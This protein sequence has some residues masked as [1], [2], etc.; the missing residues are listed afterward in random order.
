M[1]SAGLKHVRIPIAILGAL[2]A[3]ALLTAQGVAPVP[4]FDVLSSMQA[5]PE[6]AQRVER[7]RAQRVE[8]ARI[9]RPRTAQL[10]EAG[11]RG[12][13]VLVA[14]PG[15]DVVARLSHYESQPQ[16]FFAAGPL[17]RSSQ[18]GWRVDGEVAFTVV[19]GTLVGRIIVG[20]RQFRVSR[21]GTD[22]L[23]VVEEVDLVAM[24]PDGQPLAVDP[25]DVPGMAADDQ[26]GA[27]AANDSNAFVDVLMLYTPA[28]RVRFGSSAGIQAEATAAVNNANLALSNSNVTHRYRAVFVGEV[29]Y[30]ESGSSNTDLERLQA[31][32]DG[33]LDEAHGLRD[34]Y[35]AD[36][37]TLLTEASDVCG[38]GYVMGPGSVS[39]GFRTYA[40]NVTIATCASSNLSLAHEIG[41]NI[42][43]HHDRANAGSTQPSFSFAYGYAVPGVARD[44]MA[45]ACTTGG[46][47]PRRTLFSS[48]GIVFPGTSVTAGTAT[49]DNARAMGL[50][51][52]P[53]ANFRDSTC[54]YAV[55]P[56]SISVGLAGGGGSVSVTASSGCAWNAVSG[57]TSV[58]TI[59]GGA[60]STGSG[61]ASYSVGA[62][63][64]A[65][66]A[67]LTVAGQSVTVSQAATETLTVSMA[68]TTLSF[69]AT[70]TNGVLSGVTSAQTV[71]VTV[72]NGSAVPWTA[73]ASQSWVQITGGSGTGNGSFVV[74][75]T[76]PGNVLSGV[77]SASATITLAPTGATS[78]TTVSVGLTVTQVSAGAVPFGQVDTPLQNA[79]G[80]Q[81]AIGVTGWA[82]DDTGLASIRVY[83][84]CLSVDNPLSCQAILGVQ[85]VFLGDASF[86]PGARPDVETAFPGYP[87]ANRAGWGMQ[88]LTNML[89]HIPNGV[90]VGGQGAMTFYVFATDNG[91]QVSLLGRAWTREA[92]D[93][94]FFAPTTVTLANDS[95]AKP[96]GTIDTPA[97]GATLSGSVANFGWVLTP[98]ANTQAGE[99]GDILMPISGA[100]MVAY[101]DGVART[102]VAYNQCRG[103]VG[104]PVAAGVFC[105]DDIANTFGNATAQA[106]LT[107]R[108]SNPSRY[109]NLDAGRS[110]IGAVVLNT[111][112]LT[113]GLH[114]IAWGVSDSA[115]RG[116]GIGS[117]FFT[118]ANAGAGDLRSAGASAP[119]LRHGLKPV[120]SIESARSEARVLGRTGFSLDALWQVLRPDV[121]GHRYARLP[122]MGRLEL[123]LG[124]DIDEAYQIVAG[125]LRALPIGS[126]VDGP[127]FS[128]HPGPGFVGRYSLV[129]VRAGERV[130][131]DVDINPD[132]SRQPGESD[133]RMHLD[134]VTVLSAQCWSAEC[135]RTLR[136]EG[137]ALDADASLG[138]GVGAVHVWAERVQR[139]GVLGSW[140]PEVPGG[141]AAV[142]LGSAT[143]DGARPD[144][145]EA[146]GSVF[147]YAGFGL[148]A[149]L[150]PGEWTVTAYVYLT[151]TSQFEDARSRR[152]VVR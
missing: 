99:P 82:L 30:T 10:E 128:W 122:E 110:A 8:G 40:F 152:L 83:R 115:G 126:T 151:R 129:F 78:S 94:A 18:P 118:V 106:P 85:V 107:L 98:D 55:S 127:R 23:H 62:S 132:R 104:N 61:S 103:T 139:T 53:V 38:V 87:N 6:R 4:I 41:H 137:W 36:V 144:V 31:V 71:T 91:G 25:A 101:V 130:S 43:L 37:V 16:G 105:N 111:T 86:L 17:T 145:A 121:E 54:S 28:A 141:P 57:D 117:R 46:A 19:D 136:V 88:I 3:T 39:T 22:D 49:E 89:P 119:A 5:G 58:A 102:V 108:S 73:S 42:G 33:R 81:G 9:V 76:N 146:F 96:F 97:L 35:D 92:L 123:W 2:V 66:S 140:S 112:T 114:T 60:T 12:Q 29:T 133:V 109:R 21:L 7:E 11:R 138:S 90:L 84:P 142:F 75:I 50:T 59:T 67:T 149:P 56:T 131:V 1:I 14:L 148:T 52:T 124:E 143:L 13:E 32:G 74:G 150:P 116:E 147:G 68:P 95:I 72:S 70:N 15:L 77:G 24:P 125:T 135:A 48:P 113:N 45:Y 134:R 44:V 47:C 79:T 80:V 65:R 69:A 100:T 34:F 51:S 26:L 120:P 93:G 27:V 64:S 20:A 63:S